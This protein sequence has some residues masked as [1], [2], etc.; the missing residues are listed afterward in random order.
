MLP[1][2]LASL[3]LV[4]TADC[5]QHV[6]GGGMTAEQ[7]RA[8]LR[9][10]VQVGGVTFFGLRNA[11]RHDFTEEPVYKSGLGVRAGAPVRIKVAARDR[12]WLAVDYDRTDRSGKGAP[13]VRV[14]PCAPDTPHFSDDGVVGEETGYAGGFVAQR[15]GCGT[16]LVR[17]EG[18]REWRRVP[19]AFGARCP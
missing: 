1:I 4:P 2:L 12:S 10:S 9:R 15:N 3:A 5:A 7:R 13:E 11:V 6:E 14:I 17:R 18:A 16:L 8:V 19:V